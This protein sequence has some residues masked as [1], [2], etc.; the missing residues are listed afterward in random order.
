[1][2]APENALPK[3]RMTA[4]LFGRETIV[5]TSATVTMAPAT[6]STLSPIVIFLPH[7]FDHPVRNFIYLCG[8]KAVSLLFYES[9]IFT[10]LFILPDSGCV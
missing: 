9:N 6:L 3:L 5:V 7:L 8:Q 4:A 1:M 10:L 2:I